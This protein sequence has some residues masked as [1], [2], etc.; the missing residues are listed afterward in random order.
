MAW[1]NFLL[2]G[3]SHP[4]GMIPK[5]HH[6][7]KPISYHP[8]QALPVAM[9]PVLDHTCSLQQGGFLHSLS[10]RLIQSCRATCAH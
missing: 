2:G 1:F 4:A 5:L 10:N 9:M 7:A 8:L 3:D 6:N